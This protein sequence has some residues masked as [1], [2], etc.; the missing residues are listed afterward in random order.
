MLVVVNLKPA[1]LA[2]FMS[3]G[4]LLCASR[5]GEGE[6]RGE[7][8]VGEEGRERTVELVEVMPGSE[9]GGRVFV[10]HLGYSKVRRSSSNKHKSS[11]NQKA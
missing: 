9:V 5:E 6:L 8:V 4:M 11:V 7:G 10:E 2:G 3:H 1:K